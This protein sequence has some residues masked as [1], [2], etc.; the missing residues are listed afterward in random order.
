[1]AVKELIWDPMLQGNG[2]QRLKEMDRIR[3][4]TAGKAQPE[5][6]DTRPLQEDRDR[7]YQSAQFTHY[8]G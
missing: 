8:S 5:N 1:M 2:Q 4:E 6:P 3:P 7:E